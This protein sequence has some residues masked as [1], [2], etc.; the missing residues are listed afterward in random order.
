MVAV[1]GSI[2]ALIVMHIA[3]AGCSTQQIVR[4]ENKV[5]TMRCAKG[6]L[7]EG[8]LEHQQC[9][10]AYGAAAA[11]ERA[12]SQQALLGTLGVATQ[13]WSA[14]QQGRASAAMIAPQ[15]QPR[16]NRPPVQVSTPQQHALV[17]QQTD[18]NW[19]R[20]CRY[21]DGTVIS[22][23]KNLCPISITGQF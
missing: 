18:S 23:G 7:V 2:A 21:A 22:V 1:R 13:V 16:E 4:F 11:Q 5:G 6:G 8:S 15:P 17:S 10:A 9:V 14:E 3:L 12:D 19:G 20:T